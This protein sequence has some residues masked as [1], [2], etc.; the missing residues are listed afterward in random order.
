LSHSLGGTWA[1][2][3]CFLSYGVFFCCND[4]RCLTSEV[5]RHPRDNLDGLCCT[6]LA[7]FGCSRRIHAQVFDLCSLGDDLLL[8]NLDW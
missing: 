3:R 2:H 8:R 1:P 4:Y 6:D 7:G 5:W